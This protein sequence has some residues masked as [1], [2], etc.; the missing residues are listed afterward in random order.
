MTKNGRKK[1]VFILNRY[2]IRCSDL[3]MIGTHIM[4]NYHILSKQYL[5]LITFINIRS[6]STTIYIR[7]NMGR[8][9]RDETY[10][11]EELTLD[12]YGALNHMLGTFN[13]LSRGS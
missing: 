11:W 12:S 1:F 10:L 5:K 2:I 7:R 4:V 6:V 13:I 9:G 3:L 8:S